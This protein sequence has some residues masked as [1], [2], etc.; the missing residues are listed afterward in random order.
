[1]AM[2]ANFT[3]AEIVELMKQ[4]RKTDPLFKLLKKLKT[5]IEVALP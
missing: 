5:A 2:E 1:M 3:L 4:T